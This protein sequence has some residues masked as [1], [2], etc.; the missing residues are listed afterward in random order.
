LE[1]EPL[2]LRPTEV[3]KL[4]GLGR[5]KVFAMLAT[6][7]LPVVRLGRSVRVPREALERWIRERT[8]ES[9]GTDVP[10]PSHACDEPPSRIPLDR[11][12]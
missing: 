11:P 1:L 5:S 7:E 4:L 10:I 3:G 9:P 2:L 8:L 12:A 6:G